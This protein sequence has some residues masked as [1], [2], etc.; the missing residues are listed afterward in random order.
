MYPESPH[1]LIHELALK[2]ML[3]PGA[4]TQ[5]ASHKPLERILQKPN[6]KSRGFYVLQRKQEICCQ[7]ALGV[8]FS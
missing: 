8:S 7:P 5:T 3:R 2:K 6:G 4:F 1:E